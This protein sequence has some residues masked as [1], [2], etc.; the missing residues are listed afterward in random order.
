[1]GLFQMNHVKVNC[2]ATSLTMVLNIKGNGYVLHT[3]SKAKNI[4]DNLHIRAYASCLCLLVT[5][6]FTPS[7]ITALVLI[8]KVLLLVHIPLVKTKLRCRRN[9]LVPL[10]RFYLTL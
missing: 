1:M 6:L 10:L 3:T 8:L 2:N 9:L 5:N 4:M 7:E